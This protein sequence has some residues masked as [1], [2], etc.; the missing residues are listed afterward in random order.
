VSSC[1]RPEIKNEVD[2]FLGLRKQIRNAEAELRHMFEMRMRA[3]SLTSAE[4]QMV[5]EAI[6]RA[7]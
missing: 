4:D 2:S 6:D 1:I 5:Q 7:D 3:I